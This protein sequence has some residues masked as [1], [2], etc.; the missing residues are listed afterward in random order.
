[1]DH[2]SCACE[3]FRELDD[4]SKYIHALCVNMCMQLQR[5][6]WCGTSVI[7]LYLTG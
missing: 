4:V 1:M 7:Y 6:Q 3:I 5:R 2:Y